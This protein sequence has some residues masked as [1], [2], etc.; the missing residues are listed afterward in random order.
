MATVL[1]RATGYLKSGQLCL[2]LGQSG[3]GTSLLLS[4]IAGRTL[5]KFVKTNNEEEEDGDR[6]DNAPTSSVLYHHHG[7]ESTS[8]CTADRQTTSTSSNSP[9]HIVTYVGQHD[10]HMPTLTVRQTLEFAAFCKWPAYTPHADKLR[11]NDVTL[12]ARA[13][14]IEHA[15]DTIVG[16]TVLRGVSG[17]ERKRVTIGEAVVGMSTSLGGSGSGSGASVIV[18]DNWSKGL[19][20]TTTLSI[21][22]SLR[23]YA[24]KANGAVIAAMQAPGPEVFDLFDTVCVMCEGCVIYFGPTATAESYFNQLGFIRPSY[25][26]TPDFLAT[27]MDPKFRAEYIAGRVSNND[28]SVDGVDDIVDDNTGNANMC[29]PPLRTEQFVA[30]FQSSSAARDMHL[31]IEQIKQTSRNVD[32]K[33]TSS[34]KGMSTIIEFPWG[35]KHSTGNDAEV[36]ATEPSK[37]ILNPVLQNTASQLHALFRRQVSYMVSKRRTI[38]EDIIQMLVCGLLIGSMFWQLPPTLGGADSRAALTFI[39]VMYII[40]SAT[41]KSSE[42]FEEKAIFMKQRDAGFFKAW[43]FLLTQSVTLDMVIELVKVIC[44]FVPLYFMAGLS[45]GQYGQRLAYAVVMETVLSSVMLTLVRLCVASC[46]D[47]E[48]A[49]GLFGVGT[50]FFV[51]FSG[52]LKNSDEMEWYLKWIYWINPM[53]YALKAVL[54]NEFSGLEFDCAEN[55][56]IP[57]GVPLVDSKYPGIKICPSMGV[58]DTGENYLRNFRGI[59]KSD[60]FQVIH[61]LILAS[62][63]VL[64]FTATALAMTRSR[65]RGHA[66]KKSE[67][68]DEDEMN[69]KIDVSPSSNIATPGEEEGL[70]LS[71]KCNNGEIILNCRRLSSQ[72]QP[73]QCPTTA[74]TFTDIKYT[75]Q[76]GKKVLLQGVTG[77]AVGGKVT[78][79]LGTSGA[80]KT[81]LLDVCAFRKTLQRGT[82][83]SGEVRINGKLTEGPELARRSG[84]CE[85]NDLHIDRVTVFEAVLFAA[86]L[87][88]RKKGGL[89]LAEKRRRATEVLA[90]LGLSKDADTPVKLLDNGR[91]KLLTMAVEVVTEPEV[92]FLDE[93]TSGLSSCSALR[94]ARALRNIADS[95][96]TAVICTLHQ[97]SK[98]VFQVFDCVLLLRKGGMTTY[99]GDIGKEGRMI[100]KYFEKYGATPMLPHENP[101]AWML[102]VINDESINWS[103]HWLKSE[104]RRQR[105]SETAVLAK[106]ERSMY[107]QAKEETSV[108]VNE[109]LATN[110]N[111]GCSFNGQSSDGQDIHVSLPK[112]KEPTER[113]E[114]GATHSEGM[115][116]PSIAA[117]TPF[118]RAPLF[119]QLREVVYRQFQMYW[120]MPEYNGTRLCV[121]LVFAALVGLLYLRDIGTD[122]DGFASTFAALF[123]TIL[124]GMITAVQ[125]IPPTIAC[126]DAFYREVQSGT[127]RP[128]TYH[129]AVGFVE[130]PYTVVSA[131]VFATVF[132][133]MA[134]LDASRFWFFAL[135]FVLLSVVGVMLAVM[136]AAVSP[137]VQVASTVANA[138]VSMLLVLS[139]FLIRTPQMPVWWRWIKWVNPFTYYLSSVIFNEFDGK[140]FTCDQTQRILVS[141][142][143]DIANCTE[144]VS[145]MRNE[146]PE[147]CGFCAVPNGNEVIELYG[148]SDVNKWVCIVG[149]IVAIVVCRMVAAYGFTKKRFLTR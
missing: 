98:E 41:M 139:G 95:R 107:A 146:G 78:L 132:Y 60:N 72:D 86:K 68:E 114:E 105:M 8:N 97:P 135:S 104:E 11:H 70:Q 15:L 128:I 42:H 147:H 100:R 75:I 101:A 12:T 14:G 74:F 56:L 22:K 145:W 18:M 125:V 117:Q 85:Q 40:V 20:S 126:R 82:D 21:T 19:D 37:S 54:L 88:L 38:L 52:Y 67:D 47:V 118:E 108:D 79:L 57:K 110:H 124:P 99:F 55:E 63:Y 81:T 133:F 122:Q 69:V 121:S 25:R 23:T 103:E 73:Q 36:N 127:Y 112:P 111:G 77:H 61:L 87:R 106:Q 49:Q 26:T 137:T 4:R 39:A 93:P 138:T 29:K 64:F 44:M 59:T 123:L 90:M 27:V 144:L 1:D 43:A 50:L 31:E 113:A 120:R 66:K 35:S 149:L 7:D 24:D 136:L 3:S 2:V 30:C 131:M 134:G 9:S 13:L 62:F 45:V 46:D 141:R 84:Y 83:I 32:T 5:P 80:G 51:M 96:G 119:T 65:A 109:R 28:V 140:I 143:N 91:L 48:V 130:I 16:S 92:L 6:D 17:G 76:E 94:V 71:T 116:S 89:S 34:N 148:A 33:A 142:P 53:S 115:T 58:F 10:E 102:D 129:F